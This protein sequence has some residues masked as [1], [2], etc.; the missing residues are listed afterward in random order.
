MTSGKEWRERRAEGV[1]VELPS[2]FKP[3]LRALGFRTA[4]MSGMVP[5]FM[6]STVVKAAV[7]EQGQ[8]PLPDSEDQMEQKL[9]FLD[10]V[11]RAMFVSPRIVE[12]PADA[13]TD[14]EITID[15]VDD[16]DKLYLLSLMGTP[17]ALMQQFRREQI[18]AMADL[19][20]RAGQPSVAESVSEAEAGTDP[21]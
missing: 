12:K 9:K 16:T 4:L 15:D 19:F 20:A 5:D 17:T 10:D 13:L 11:A 21:G 14:D 3:R 6:T 7:G 1:E 18:Q 8:L 2:G